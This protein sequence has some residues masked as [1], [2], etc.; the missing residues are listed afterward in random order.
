MTAILLLNE[1]QIKILL[2]YDL[3]KYDAS[4]VFFIG[5]QTEKRERGEKRGN[6]RKEMSK[7]P[8]LHLNLSIFI[9]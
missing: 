2:F 7:Y 8:Q 5:Q 3:G 9:D 4:K 6:K 1:L